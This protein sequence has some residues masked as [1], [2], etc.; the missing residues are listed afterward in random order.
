MAP[1]VR[2]NCFARTAQPD[3]PLLVVAGAGSGKTLT[4]IRHL[5]GLENHRIED[6]MEWFASAAKGGDISAAAFDAVFMTIIRA[7]ED[8]LTLSER[9]RA[10]SLVRVH[11]HSRGSLRMM[12]TQL[13]TSPSLRRAHAF[14][15]MR[16]PLRMVPLLER[17]VTLVEPSAAR[18]NARWM[19]LTAG[20][21]MT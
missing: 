6:V 10:P 11:A 5:T 19:L 20:W 17:S 15:S 4:M 12:A 21:L 9:A 14:F 1:R 3:R 16:V 2:T 18:L 8:A 13:T 7:N